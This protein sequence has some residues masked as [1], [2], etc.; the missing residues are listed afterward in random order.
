MTW[1]SSSF[2]VCGTCAV[3]IVEGGNIHAAIGEGISD[4]PAGEFA[5]HNV[6]DGLEDGHIDFLLDAAQLDAGIFIGGNEPVGIH[7]DDQAFSAVWQ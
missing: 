1:V 2:K 5:I 3:E 7:A 4:G 6:L